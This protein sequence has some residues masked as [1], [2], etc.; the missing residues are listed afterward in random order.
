MKVIAVARHHRA[1]AGAAPISSCTGGLAALLADGLGRAACSVSAAQLVPELALGFWRELICDTFVPLDL[2]LPTSP[3]S[4]VELSTL[5]HEY[6]HDV[7]VLTLAAPESGRDD[8]VT[9]D[10]LLSPSLSR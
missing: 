1:G 8:Q 10:P 5:G 6:D 7:P 3:R 2:A 9:E 4:K